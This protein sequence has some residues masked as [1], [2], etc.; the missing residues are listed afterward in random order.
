MAL[1]DRPLT[2]ARRR[3]KVLKAINALVDASLDWPLNI[4][5]LGELAEAIVLL[6]YV[7]RQLDGAK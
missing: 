4:D 1:L 6:D 5:A 2:I 7:L 3:R